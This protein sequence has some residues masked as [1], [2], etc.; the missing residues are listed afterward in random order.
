MMREEELKVKVEEVNKIK[1]LE[2]QFIKRVHEFESRHKLPSRFGR[3]HLRRPKFK[4][5]QQWY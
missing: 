3:H 1:K 2:G 4:K 5:N